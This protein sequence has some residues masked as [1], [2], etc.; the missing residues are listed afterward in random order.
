MKSRRNAVAAVALLALLNA[1][2]A[3]ADWNLPTGGV[4]P[5][6]A[7]LEDLAV[8]AHWGFQILQVAL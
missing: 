3:A 6:D 4:A 1:G 5:P 8:V 7:G 2:P